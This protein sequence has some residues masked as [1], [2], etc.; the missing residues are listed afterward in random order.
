MTRALVIDTSTS[1][2]SV[3]VFND[4]VMVWEGFHDGAMDHGRALSEL[5][6]LALKKLNSIDEVHVGMGPGPYTGLRVG[7]AFARAFAFARELPLF[8][9]CSLDAITSTESDY[10]AVTDARRKE[11]YWALYK[12]GARVDGPFVDFPADL[13]AGHYVGEGAVKYK[14]SDHE[15][16]PNM[17][18]A[19]TLRGNITEALYLRRP[20][21]LPTSERR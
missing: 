17:H 11:V 5:V 16:F 2:T 13:P 3:G 7:I 6:G 21:A 9:F 18:K 19:L 4:G 10:I 12:N 1:R 20:D 14:L 15:G 8:G